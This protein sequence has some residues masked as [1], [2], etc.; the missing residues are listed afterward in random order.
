MRRRG[1][2]WGFL[3]RVDA[4]DYDQPNEN[5]LTRWRL[6]STPWFGLYVH[7]IDKPDPRPTL[8]DHPWPFVTFV[9]KGG[10]TE[11]FGIRAMRGGDK[12]GPIVKRV[13]RSWRRGSV[14]RMRKTDAHT[15]TSAIAPTWTLLVVGR[16]R[17]DPSWGYWDEDGD[18][19]WTPFD[20]HPHAAEFAAAKAARQLKD[21]RRRGWTLDVSLPRELAEDLR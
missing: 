16:R 17:Q 19:G 4:P 2:A 13:S 11:D 9:L 6:I 3:E 1:Q 8:H 20:Q 5:Y 18:Y 15:I 21:D 14:H 12:T 10:Y 7:R